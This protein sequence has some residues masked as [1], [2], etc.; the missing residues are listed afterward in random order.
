[1][2]KCSSVE[3]PPGETKSQ[4]TTNIFC[5]ELKASF[6]RASFHPAHFVLHL[7]EVEVEC[8]VFLPHS[9]SANNS[10]ICNTITRFLS[11]PVKLYKPMRSLDALAVQYVFW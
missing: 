5:N 4:F 6:D 1:M 7:I 2:C 10:H 9:E 8:S 11:E 3:K